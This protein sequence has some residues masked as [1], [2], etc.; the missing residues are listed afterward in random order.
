MNKL[1]F[2]KWSKNPFRMG[3][4]IPSSLSVGNCFANKIDKDKEGYIIEAGA[5]T[6]TITKSLI[7]N[8]IDENRIIS[9]EID[10]DF[11]DLLGKKFSN[12][13]VVNDDILNLKSIIK[14]E[15]VNCIVST[16]PLLSLGKKSKEILNLFAEFVENGSDYFQLS[17]SPFLGMKSK[18][19]GVN[20]RKS[21]YVLK[22]FPPAYIY[23]CFKS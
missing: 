1:F 19:F 4:I 18:K 7:E 15:E 23:Q 5:G 3:S 22:N 6:G 14:L 11:C 13:R 8:G 9:F 21:A 17:Y 10:A 12:I 2:K 20:L 16:L